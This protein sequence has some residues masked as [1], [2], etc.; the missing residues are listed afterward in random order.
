MVCIS[1]SVSCQLRPPTISAAWAE[2]SSRPYSANA[3]DCAGQ[4]SLSQD[5][6]NGQI[7]HLFMV[8][9]GNSLECTPY[10]LELPR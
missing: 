7:G 5:A 8:V 9:L 1:W 6:G 10:S 2:A 3:N 4:G